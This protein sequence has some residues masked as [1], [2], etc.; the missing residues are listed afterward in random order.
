MIDTDGISKGL[1]VTI[2]IQDWEQA[3]DLG[4]AFLG[5][6]FRGQS[7]ASWALSSTI[8]RIA[9]RYSCPASF[10]SLTLAN[11]EQAYRPCGM[12][13]MGSLSTIS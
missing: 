10:L 4:R 11:S 12:R 3:R 1:M 7:D 5:F 2:R 9:K 6:V 13:N 8:E